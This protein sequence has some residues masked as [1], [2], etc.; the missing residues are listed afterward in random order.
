MT[1]RDKWAQRDCVMRYRAFKDK[2]RES[3][4]TLPQPG[5]V[6]FTLPMPGSWSKTKRASLD[7][8][9][10]LLKPDVDNLLKAL[11]DALYIDDAHIW[12]VAVE[13]RWGTAGSIAIG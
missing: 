4:L 10:H 11:L 8:Q 13:K 7:G 9:P 1:R 12:S 6:L 2:V 5:K 3:G